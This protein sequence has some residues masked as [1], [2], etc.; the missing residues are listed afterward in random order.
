MVAK[1][2]D[3]PREGP[4]KQESSG[5]MFSNIN[6]KYW[7][8]GNKYYD[9]N[10][11]KIPWLDRH[12]GGRQV[13]ELARDRFDDCTYAFEVPLNLKPPCCLTWVP[14]ASQAYHP[15]YVKAREILKKYEVLVC[16]YPPAC[17]DAAAWPVRRCRAG[18]PSSRSQ[19]GRCPCPRGACAT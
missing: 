10:R 15:D 13:L 9:F 7:R 3:A 5:V 1:G 16:D 4:H 2:G 6:R 19:T 12:P 11:G 14:M 17:P 18:A 8:I